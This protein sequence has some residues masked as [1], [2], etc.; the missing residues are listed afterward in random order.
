MMSFILKWILPKALDLILDVVSEK[1]K[2]T[3]SNIDDKIL[4]VLK[5]EKRQIIEAAKNIRRHKRR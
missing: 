1:V 5:S 4:N 3:S 2:D